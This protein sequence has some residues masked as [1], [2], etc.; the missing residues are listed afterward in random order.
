MRTSPFYLLTCA[1]ALVAVVV[2]GASKAAAARAA[3]SMAQAVA[4]DSPEDRE[5][6]HAV[7]HSYAA[8][9]GGLGETAAVVFLLALGA[10]V[11]SLR[12][13][14]RGLQSI[15]LLLLCLAGLL[16]LLMV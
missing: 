8:Q 16:Q 4:A 7:A 5:A 15:P 14:E 9:S 3:I 13:R 2:T 1:L 12:R 10:W 11:W 6:L